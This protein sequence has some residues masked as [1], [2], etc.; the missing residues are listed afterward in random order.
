MNTQRNHR[1]QG[2]RS[3]SRLLLLGKFEAS[4]G[5][6][7]HPARCPA[8]FCPT[9]CV[10]LSLPP[11]RKPATS[12]TRSR[13]GA[14]GESTNPS[15][16][17]SQRVGRA[18]HKPEGGDLECA[19]APRVLQGP[20]GF[21]WTGGWGRLR[22]GRRPGLLVLSLPGGPLS[23]LT[24]FITWTCLSHPDQTSRMVCATRVLD[25]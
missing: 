4:A 14:P 3:H 19:E 12:P 6:A 10:S 22:V 21:L 15:L 13:R 2:L 25:T 20:Q 7:V 23:F 18:P 8:A 5:R 9:R 17:P 1:R 24:E 11:G 16:V